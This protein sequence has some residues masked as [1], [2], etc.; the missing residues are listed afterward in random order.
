MKGL[1]V[2]HSRWGNCRRVAEAVTEGLQETGHEVVLTDVRS[3]EALDLDLE[4][5]VVGSPTRAGRM[6]GKARGLIKREVTDA[7][8]GKPFAAFGTG[9]ES[10][11]ESSKPQSADDIR[12]ALLAKGLEP[13]APPFKA[14]VKG[15]KG[16]L[17][18]DDIERA[19][20]FG[21][22]IGALLREDSE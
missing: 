15:M 14:A 1:V 12:Q 20:E 16:P 13:I 8:D 6:T 9:L 11:L 5:L 19:R 7:W 22:D 17:L 10:G 4:F 21:R 3:V 2:Y 18:E